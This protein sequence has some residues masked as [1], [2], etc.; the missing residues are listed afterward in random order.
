MTTLPDTA[1]GLAFEIDDEDVVPDDQHL[2]EME[3]TVVTDLHRIKARRQQLAQPP[4]QQSPLLHH[5][6]D[7]P[8]MLLFQ[9]RP[10]AHELIEGLV[11]A[12]ELASRHPRMSSDVIASG[13]KAAISSRLASASCSSATRRPT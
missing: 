6:V 1:P 7:E 2:A 13:A 5:L 10:A 4:R 11:G 9:A 8:A 12:L 3:V